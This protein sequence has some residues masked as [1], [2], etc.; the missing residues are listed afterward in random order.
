MY[1]V[2]IY[3]YVC[4]PVVEEL[5]RLV[6]LS[7]LIGYGCVFIHIVLLGTDVYSFTVLLGTDV[8][9]FTVLLG[10]DVYSFTVLLGTDVYSFT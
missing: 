6:L 2:Y 5:P 3:T 10:T 4:I 7:S 8:Y 9:S 1:N